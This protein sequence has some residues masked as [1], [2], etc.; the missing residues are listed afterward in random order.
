MREVDPLAL[1]RPVYGTGLDLHADLFRASEEHRAEHGSGCTVYPSSPLNI[2]LWFLLAAIVHARRFLEVGC[3]L[4][5]TAAILAETGGPESR[6]DTIESVDAHADLAEVA[7]AQRGLAGRVRV[8]RGEA[9]TVLSD[10]R[11]PYDL[12]F[13]DSDW[14]EYTALLPDLTR[15]TRRG[16]VLVTANIS[17]QRIDWNEGVREYLTRLVADTQFHTFVIPG[18]WRAVSYRLTR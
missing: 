11:D 5:Y 13:I 3:G 16:G 6:V 18:F 10:L 12:V 15:L 8:L 17:P 7:L 4:G 1:L 14:N 2:P 9:K